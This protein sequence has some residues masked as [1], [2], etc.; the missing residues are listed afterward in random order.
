[1]KAVRITAERACELADVERDTSGV[2]PAV[3]SARTL[4]TLISPGT[5]LNIFLGEY[6][7]AGAGWGSFPATPG[8]AAVAEVEETGEEVDDL[9]AGDLIFCAG[10]HQGC[11]RVERRACLPVPEG[12]EPVKAPYA[13]I[14][15]VTFSTYSTT[16]VRP[17]ETVMVVGLGLVGLL[18]AQ[19][20]RMA[21]YRVVGVEPVEARRRI[22]VE[23]GI[24]TVLPAVPVDDPAWRGKVGLVLE[25]S[26]H[27]RAVVD[28][29]WC[30][31]KGGEIVLVGVPMSAKTDALAHD[32]YKAVFRAVA[33]MRSGTEWQVP[34]YPDGTGKPS[35]W[36]NMERALGFLA[37][38]AVNVNGLHTMAD[39][40]DCQ[41]AYEA[42]LEK[43]ID[44]LTV[45][46]DWTQ[47]SGASWGAA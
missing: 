30:L 13:R 25:C 11:Q 32:A 17:P 28:A 36:G 43:R 26:A 27:E 45:A 42:V 46:F 20:F 18:G 40:A 39:P 7:R 1:M 35:I 2:A 22:A 5:E 24:E 21:G 10:P 37:S 9:Q 47:I 8:Y 12:L 3:V 15:N 34:R 16:A 6:D 44:G 31:R 29:T 23:H 14:M 38:G 4:Y 33:T 41:S 19:L